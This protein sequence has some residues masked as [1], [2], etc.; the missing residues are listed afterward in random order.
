MPTATDPVCQ[1]AVDTANPNG[2]AAEYQGA[3]YYFCAPGCR[4]AFEREPERVLSGELAIDMSH[5][6]P[7]AAPKRSLF[8]RL[9]GKG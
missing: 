4:I 2:G 3:T 8:A 6:E 1:M 9:F 5:H 7:P